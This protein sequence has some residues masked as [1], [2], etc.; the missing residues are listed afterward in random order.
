MTQPHEIPVTVLM[1]AYNAREYIHAAITSVLAQTYTRFE[2]L[3]V[4]DGSS[5]DTQAV[6]GKTCDTRIRYIWQPHRGVA[7]ALNYGLAH[8]RGKFIARLDADD[9]ADPQRL[10]KQL[11]FLESHTDHVLVGSDAS[12]LTENG[13]H[14]FDFSCIA[15]THDEIMKKLYSYCPFI[16]S[17]VMYRKDAVTGAGGYPVHAHNFEDYL[18]WT[19][20]PAFG[21]FHNLREKL[22]SVRFNPSSVTMDEKWRSRRFRELKRQ[23]ILRGS[24]S[25]EE[26][27]ELYTLLQSQD[28]THIKQAAY[29]ALCAKKLLVNNYQPEKARG[30]I[31]SSILH[32]PLRLDNYALLLSSY[33]PHAVLKWM[34]RKTGMNE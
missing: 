27:D 10:E 8:A 19:R 9:M 31:R 11:H 13:E 30:H 14:L 33:L 4:D 5:D 7:A 22:V 34:Q 23:A 3:V 17:S 32:R 25:A 24:I 18:L 20:L 26:G 16:H 15:Y 1:P 28:I 6:A 29:H 21:K 12:Y 2:L